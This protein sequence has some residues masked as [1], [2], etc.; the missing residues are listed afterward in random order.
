MAHFVRLEEASDIRHSRMPFCS[1]YLHDSIAQICTLTCSPRHTEAELMLRLY[2]FLLVLLSHRSLTLQSGVHAA[3]VSPISMPGDAT[4]TSKG[5]LTGS[6]SR[7]AP[8]A[9]SESAQQDSLP[10]TGF[11]PFIGPATSAAAQSND[12][13]I[14]QPGY[15]GAQHSRPVTLHPSPN[16]A[17]TT[18]STSGMPSATVQRQPVSDSMAEAS[19]VSEGNSPTQEP[20]DAPQPFGSPSAIPL[21]SQPE[22]ATTAGRLAAASP[23][24]APAPNDSWNS[25]WEEPFDSPDQAAAPAPLPEPDSGSALLP[26][27]TQSQDVPSS[28]PDEAHA[29]GML[30]DLLDT[31]AVDEGPRQQQHQPD[32]AISAL[33]QLRSHSSGLPDQAALEGLCGDTPHIGVHLPDQDAVSVSSLSVELSE[34]INPAAADASNL[35]AQEVSDVLDQARPQEPHVSDVSNIVTESLLQQSSQL[36]NM[37]DQASTCGTTRDSVPDVATTFQP[38]EHLPD[39]STP[40]QI[41]SGA[42]NQTSTPEL[43]S[44]MPDQASTPR[45]NRS[46]PDQA[47]TPHLKTRLPELEM[48]SHIPKG[49]S[50]RGVSATPKTAGVR[51]Y[52]SWWTPKGLT[53]AWLKTR[54]PGWMKK[55]QQPGMVRKSCCETC[56]CMHC[57]IPGGHIHISSFLSILWILTLPAVMASQIWLDAA[58]LLMTSAASLLTCRPACSHA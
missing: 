52:G 17:G 19:G 50:A 10:T 5:T 20:S 34:V 42:P 46:L 48:L 40:S 14:H 43:I 31:T 29:G 13:V 56:H 49:G 32:E 3:S 51:E 6:V 16:M 54:T 55:M 38:Y 1:K 11:S 7:L 24:Q 15:M 4:T 45:L 57:C 30:A 25:L 33:L 44:S 28:Q 12:T 58:V 9:A 23:D 35:Q 47:T 39:Q 26:S 21:P 37:L 2:P 36:R 41:H 18:A 53:P 27:S 8:Q 22:Q